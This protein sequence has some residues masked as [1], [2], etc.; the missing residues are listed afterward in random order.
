MDHP[1]KHCDKADIERKTL[2]K[3]EK[4]CKQY[5][6]CWYECENKLIDILVGG[7]EHII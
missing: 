1:C 2:E 5:N 6:K 4:P 3:C 7:L